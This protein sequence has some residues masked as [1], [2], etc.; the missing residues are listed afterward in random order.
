MQ[1]PYAVLIDI[2]KMCVGYALDDEDCPELHR[3]KL[4]GIQGE[5]DDL[6]TAAM[7]SKS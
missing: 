7:A 5:L 1:T 2:A 3:P 6:Y 4:V